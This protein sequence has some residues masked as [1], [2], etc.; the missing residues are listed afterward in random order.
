MSDEPSLAKTRFQEAENWYQCDE[1]HFIGWDRS[2]KVWVKVRIRSDRSSPIIDPWNPES[3]ILPLEP[4][5]LLHHPSG[6]AEPLQWDEISEPNSDDLQVVLT[7][8]SIPPVVTASWVKTAPPDS[9]RKLSAAVDALEAE[10]VQAVHHVLQGDGFEI[11]GYLGGGGWGE[12]FSVRGANGQ[13]YALKIMKPPYDD[14]WLRRLETEADSMRALSQHDGFVE[15]HQ[16]PR[17]AGNLAFEPPR[18]S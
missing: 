6:S 17:F 4:V 7:R 18:V 12:V 3:E 15:L 14:E 13:R 11:E 1:N 2:K 10:D 8:A 5:P 16:G 9:L